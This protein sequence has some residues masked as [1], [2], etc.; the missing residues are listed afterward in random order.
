MALKHPINKTQF[1]G[2]LLFTIVS[3]FFSRTWRKS[4]PKAK[5]K[6]P[7]EFNES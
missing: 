6:P 1:S 3:L 2:F 5:A 7:V 4:A